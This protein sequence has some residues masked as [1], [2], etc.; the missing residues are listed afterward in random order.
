[1]FSSSVDPEQAV[2]PTTFVQEVVLRKIKYLNVWE[3]IRS[4]FQGGTLK[5][6]AIRN[7]KKTNIK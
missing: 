3:N 5:M 6:Y 2:L 4:E 7:T 1:M